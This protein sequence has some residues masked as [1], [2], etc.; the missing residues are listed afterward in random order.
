MKLHGCRI[1]EVSLVDRPANLTPFHVLKG[2]GGMEV[3]T[4]FPFEEVAFSKSASGADFCRVSGLVYTVNKMDSQGDYIAEIPEIQRCAD[5]WKEGGEVLGLLHRLKLTKE[6]AKPVVS[7][8]TGGSWMMSVD[9]YDPEL[10]SY[11]RAGKLTG[12]SMGGVAAADKPRG[13]HPTKSADRAQ[14]MEARIAERVAYDVAQLKEEF[15]MLKSDESPEMQAVAMLTAARDALA[16]VQAIPD[17]VPAH[18][19][20]KAD[21]LRLAQIEQKVMQELRDMAAQQAAVERAARQEEENMRMLWQ[22]DPQ[23]AAALV[24]QERLQA[25]YAAEARSQRQYDDS[26]ARAREQRLHGD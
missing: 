2:N 10:I 23:G 20:A 19:Q 16:A 14:L 4:Y 12:F 3:R 17:G 21:E 25:E 11:V 22:V 9:V 7:T 24:E 26:R 15:P 6:Q 5:T 18:L 8:V 13:G 1:D